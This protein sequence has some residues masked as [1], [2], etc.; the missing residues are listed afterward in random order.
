MEILNIISDIAV[1]IILIL[2][3]K[4]MKK[5]DNLQKQIEELKKWTIL[6]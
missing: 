2:Y 6:N 1:I 3:L 4:D 5:I